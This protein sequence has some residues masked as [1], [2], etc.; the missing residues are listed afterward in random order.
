MSLKNELCDINMTEDDIVVS[1]FVRISYLRYQL[2]DIEEVIP[3]TKLVSIALNG[4]SRSWEAFATNM[5]TRKE[6][7]TFE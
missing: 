1:Y 5:N 7:P 2:Q 3:E 6:F 4:L